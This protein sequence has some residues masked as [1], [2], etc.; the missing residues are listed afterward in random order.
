MTITMSEDGL[1][2]IGDVAVVFDDTSRIRWH[3][4]ATG[5]TLRDSWPTTAERDT[6]HRHLA[7]G[8]TALVVTDNEPIRVHA[9]ASELPGARPGDRPGFEP[10]DISADHFDWLPDEPRLRGETFVAEQKDYWSTRP[11][12]LRPPLVLSGLDLSSDLLRPGHITFGLIAPGISRGHVERGLGHAIMYL[13]SP[14][15]TDE[16]GRHT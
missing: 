11:G 14:A 5:W 10:V 3:R 8:G 2:L 1:L 6:L 9:L 7:A 12:L 4:T 13:R 15:A 16:R